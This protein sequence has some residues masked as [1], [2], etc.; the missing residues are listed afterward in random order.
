MPR[1]K[2]NGLEFFLGEELGSVGRGWGKDVLT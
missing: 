1:E 2:N